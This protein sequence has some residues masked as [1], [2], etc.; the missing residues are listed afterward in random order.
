MEH[1]TR[2]TMHHDRQKTEGRRTRRGQSLVELA[3]ILPV[4]LLVLGFSLDLGRA[5]L[6]W[7]NL[8]NAVRIGSNYAS[9]HPDANWTSGG[10]P[11]RQRYVAMINGDVATT[12][13]P[14][15]SVSMPSFSGST[16]G[17]TVRVSLSC[18]FRFITP[19]LTAVLGNQVTMSASAVFPVRS[20][21]YVPSAPLP[22][23]TPIPS[24]SPTPTPSPDPTASPTESP[25]PSPTP[26][27][28]T[29]PTFINQRVNDAQSIWNQAGFT[30]TVVKQAGSGNYIIGYQSL[31]AGQP[32]LCDTIVTVGP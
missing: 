17:S 1:C 16:L 4:T 8:Q 25:S 19:L 3:V 12:N 5:F 31:V 18:Q 9:L 26:V 7:V 22:T 2:G 15:T 23:P 13:C 32:Y 6:G 10:D 28:C 11:H 14:L 21:E 24:P 29:A 30:T 20:G 27:P